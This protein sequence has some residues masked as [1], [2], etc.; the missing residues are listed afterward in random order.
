[1]MFQERYAAIIGL[2]IGSPAAAGGS[3]FVAAV[4]E[5]Q[6]LDGTDFTVRELLLE[7]VC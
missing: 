2:L 6:H 3:S 5:E 4:T 1:M 7:Y